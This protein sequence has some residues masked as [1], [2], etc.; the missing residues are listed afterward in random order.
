MS[1]TVTLYKNLS[2][3][4]RAQ[5]DLTTIATESCTFKGDV[6]VMAPV[7]IFEGDAQTYAYDVNYM[8]IDA[9]RRFY[10]CTV[11]SLTGGLVQ[12]SGTVDVLTSA[13]ALGLPSKRAIIARQEN[14]YN[15][16][17]N[18]GTLK[19]YANDMIQTLEWPQGFS[20]PKYVCIVAG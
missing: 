6:D 5:K 7:L 14:N 18:D 4:K 13:W 8:Y 3:R 16:Y 12:L 2:D 20:T 19:A 15:L 17:L 10:F 1:V 9:F 11:K